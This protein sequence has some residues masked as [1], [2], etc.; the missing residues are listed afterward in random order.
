MVI[1][2]NYLRVWLIRIKKYCDIN[3]T[4]MII[5]FGIKTFNEVN[6][7][8]IFFIKDFIWVLYM[9][10]N[11]KFYLK[12]NGYLFIDSGLLLTVTFLGIFFIFK[13]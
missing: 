4:L 1:Y 3:V 6:M 11:A 7:I 10:E 9:F 5:Y 13:Y 8:C 2:I 12:C